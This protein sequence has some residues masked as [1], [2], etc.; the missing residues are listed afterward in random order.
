MAVDPSYTSGARCYDCG[1][2]D[3]T[4]DQEEE[5]EYC[6][7]CGGGADEFG[8]CE[9]VCSECGGCPRECEEEK[10][11]PVFSL[12]QA[13]ASSADRPSKGE[14]LKAL[15]EIAFLGYIAQANAEQI[16]MNF[17]KDVNK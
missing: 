11:E 13:V 4:C 7:N 6:K 16:E 12:L 1:D 9:N 3:C 14:T 10:V 5:V 2:K 15:L 17:D 8:W